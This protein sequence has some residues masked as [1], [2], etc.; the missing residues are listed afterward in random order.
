M[1]HFKTLLLIAILSLGSIGVLSANEIMVEQGLDKVAQVNPTMQTLFLSN[2]ATPVMLFDLNQKIDNKASFS[3]S[4]LN[5]ISANKGVFGVKDIA[6]ELSFSKELSTHN[7]RVERFV[8]VY[9]G[10]PVLNGEMRVV[11]SKD[12]FIKRV[13][14]RFKPIGGLSTIPGIDYRNAIAIAWR[15]VYGIDAA[16]I[17]AKRFNKKLTKLYITFTGDEARLAY[18]VLLPIE[19]MTERRVAYIDAHTGELIRQF[20][21]VR[22]D[23]QREVDVWKFNPGYD[24]LQAVERASLSYVDMDQTGDL[25]LVGNKHD[26]FGCPNTGE[27]I[28]IMGFVDIPICSQVATAAAV[29]GNFIFDPMDPNNCGF[30]AEGSTEDKFAEAHMYYHVEKIYEYYQ[31]LGEYIDSSNPPFTDLQ[32]VKDGGKLRSIVNFQT[33]DLSDL[34]A[35]MQPGPKPL[36]AFDNAFFAPS[37]GGIIEMI[38]PGDSI[39]FGQ[40]TDLDFSY[41]AD[42]IYHEFTHA[43]VD[44][45]TSLMATL[46]DQ[47]G[48]RNDPGSMNE[49]YAD[50]FSSTNTGNPYMGEYSGPRLGTPENTPMRDL[51]GD[52]T[53]PG[54][55]IGEIHN[56]SL[57]WSSAL[58][59]IREKFTANGLHDDIDAAIFEALTEAPE[60]STFDVMAQTTANVIGEWLDT[61]KESA[62]DFALAEFTTRGLI[63]SDRARTFTKGEKLDVC[64]LGSVSELSPYTPGYFQMKIDVPAG[65]NEIFVDFSSIA[66]G[67]MAGATSV[68]LFA[69]H[70]GALLFTYDTTVTN[71]A[72]LSAMGMESDSAHPSLN[73]FIV[74]LHKEDKSELEAGTWYLA[75]GNRSSGG[76]AIG[77]GGDTQIYNLS[78]DYNAKISCEL[79]D[80]CGDCEV[81][82]N[83][84]ECEP[85][86]P[87]CESDDDC[88]EHE[89]CDSDNCYTCQPAPTECM[90]ALDCDACQLCEGGYCIDIAPE[91]E[92]DNDCEAGYVCEVGECGGNCVEAETDGDEGGTE[93]GDKDE[94]KT[95]EEQADCG[96]C[97][98]CVQGICIEIESE[99]DKDKD[100]EDGQVC[101]SSECGGICQDKDGDDNDDDDG[102]AAT[103]DDG[104]GGCN[105]TGAFAGWLLLTL[106]GLSIF[107][108][109]NE[110]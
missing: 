10:V 84:G 37:Q 29:D 32:M 55:I 35:L 5:F 101:I 7:N 105:N 82:G 98:I 109:R 62:K 108:K 73:R 12:G 68:E 50:F 71:D 48:L 89:I 58:W 78:I 97:E 70:D 103:G 63:G 110:V 20:N 15:E 22:F 18:E 72:D 102:Q 104:S 106:L 19:I 87:E 9:N 57:P 46:S 34:G 2:D 95:C 1:K 74:S 23:T 17:D 51:S 53:V 6:S 11:I 85:V 93:D 16:R 59:T 25:F 54:D 76:G 64:M 44:T 3:N 65:Q 99:C 38:I 14:N 45:V 107:R 33:I 61:T 100:C 13:H 80:H 39:V 43:V 94:V 27:T 8:Q 36:V 41:D 49:G 79:D 47:Y 90:T 77:G 21:R 42:V 60:E 96:D 52:N 56:D 83:D 81:C 67:G 69:K 30:E 88:D 4:A 31:D 24:G 92:V 40:G 28:N 75:M 91:C 66:T 86:A 26:T